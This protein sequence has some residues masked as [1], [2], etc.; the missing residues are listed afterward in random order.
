MKHLKSNEP[1]ISFTLSLT[2]FLITIFNFVHYHTHKEFIFRYN[3][4][5][6]IL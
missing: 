3:E 5:E 2:Y 6:D 4:I 1:T